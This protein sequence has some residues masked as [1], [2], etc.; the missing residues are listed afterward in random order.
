MMT[1]GL[2]LWFNLIWHLVYVGALSGPDRPV[3]SVYILIFGL[4]PPKATYLFRNYFAS[5]YSHWVR[6][7]CYVLTVLGNEQLR[8]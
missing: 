3:W 5:D 1:E 4:L 2:H 7:G 8:R 6:I